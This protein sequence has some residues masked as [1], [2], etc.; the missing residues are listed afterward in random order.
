MPV[1]PPLCDQFC[2]GQVHAAAAARRR[3]PEAQEF[4]ALFNSAEDVFAYARHLP[5]RPDLGDPADGPRIQCDVS[6]RLEMDPKLLKSGRNCLEGTAF[7]LT[8]APL[9][10]PK[11]IFSSTT[12]SVNGQMHTYPVEFINGRPIAI[13]IDP[14]E[15]VP[16]NVRN[17]ALYATGR[18]SPLFNGNLAR[19]FGD[20]A[21]NACASRGDPKCYPDVT[22]SMSTALIH[23]RRWISNVDD[24]DYLL[25]V[26]GEDAELYGVFGQVGYDRMVRSIRNL[27]VSL[28]KKAVGQY[29]DKLVTQV[30]PIA[31]DVVK[32]ALIAQFGPAAA[33]ALQDKKLRLSPVIKKSKDNA[34]VEQTTGKRKPTREEC[35]RR[36]RRMSPAFFLANE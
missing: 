4:A 24:L 32:A 22:N 19:W 12:T 33:F 5:F 21:R 14:H 27:S 18:V 23:G 16:A 35:R 34:K 31:G 2:L 20:L 11:R 28:S 26:A 25:T 10:E 30:E 15:V 7:V 36:A 9:V 13:D 8:Y 1:V 17:G 3:T 29:L 6:Q